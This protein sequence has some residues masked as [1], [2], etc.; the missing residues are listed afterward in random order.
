MN[1]HNVKPY[2]HTLQPGDHV[3]IQA[4]FLSIALRDE[5]MDG[6][7]SLTASA[8]V[9]TCGLSHALALRTRRVDSTELV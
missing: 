1:V 8:I 2:R 3:A 6:Q 7:D 5:T 9:C 4:E